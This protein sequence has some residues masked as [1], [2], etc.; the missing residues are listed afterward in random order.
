MKLRGLAQ[1]LSRLLLPLFLLLNAPA[2][3]AQVSTTSS[4]AFQFQDN[5]WVNLHH[6]VRAESHRRRI[7]TPLTLPLAVLS[8][9]DRAAWTKALD[10]Y[11]DLANVSL[12]YNERLI[13]INN[14]LALLP[15][16]SPVPSGAIDPAI[17]SALNSAAPIYRGHL[18][19]KHRAE[20]D[21]WI[22]EFAPLV[23][24]HA[25][26]AIKALAAAYH[27]N[28]PTA[29]LLVDVSCESGPTEAYT[30]AGP[31]GTSGHTVLSPAKTS[32]PDMALETVFHEAS[33]TVDDQIMKMLDGEAARQHVK[34]HPELWH[35]LIFYT[36]GEIVK[37]ELG[38]KSDKFYE[39]Y[40]YRFNLYARSSW[41][42][43]RVALEK[44]WLPYL[45][46]KTTFDTALRDLVRDSAE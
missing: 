40:A 43:L 29:P 9:N 1:L 41:Q 12:I 33:H 36:A 4:P 34:I 14:T 46:G 23:Q 39:P 31:P 5:F 7:R 30:T 18:W 24:Q 11:E 44:D 35:A 20:N 8:G 16:S 37:R 42:S 17:A 2:A 45:E 3:P 38:R 15:E 25:A 21:R 19:E 22:A 13:R 27:V 32:E 28:W 10:A 6:F 26:T